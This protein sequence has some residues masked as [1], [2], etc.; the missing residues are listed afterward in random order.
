MDI[1]RATFQPGTARRDSISLDTFLYGIGASTSALG[2][3]E[4]V[5][6]G[7]IKCPRPGTSEKLGVVIV[8][9]NAVEEEDSAASDTSDGLREA[10]V[11]AGF[12]PAGI[13]GVEIRVEGCIAL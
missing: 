3:A 1:T 10:F 4:I 13:K 8:R 11:E 5:I 2:K 9:G 12:K 7:D 6:R